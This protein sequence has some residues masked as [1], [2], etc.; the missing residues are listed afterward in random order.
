MPPPPSKSL[1][2]ALQLPVFL[3]NWGEDEPLWR[4]APSLGKALVSPR[5]SQPR[6]PRREQQTGQK[7]PLGFQALAPAPHSL[8][9]LQ[10]REPTSHP[11]PARACSPSL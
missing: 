1:T 6:G 11:L 7:E 5:F 4:R 3:L 2:R 8:L 10:G 9:Q